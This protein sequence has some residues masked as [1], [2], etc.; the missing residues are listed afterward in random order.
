[1]SSVIDI[2]G[3]ALWCV[4]VSVYAVIPA[5]PLTVGGLYIHIPFT[6]GLAI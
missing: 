6:I 1:M 5:R 4:C 3:T 2:S